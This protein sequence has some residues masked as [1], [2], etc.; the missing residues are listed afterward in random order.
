MS[1]SIRGRHP[2]RKRHFPY[3][4]RQIDEAVM[5]RANDHVR[6][7][8]PGDRYLWALAHHLVYRGGED[9]RKSVRNQAQIKWRHRKMK[10]AQLRQWAYRH[11]RDD[12]SLDEPTNL[13]IVGSTFMES[14]VPEFLVIAVDDD[15]SDGLTYLC[16][17]ENFE[18][19]V[20]LAVTEGGL[21][22]GAFGIQGAY[23]EGPLDITDWMVRACRN[24][25]ADKLD[26]L[27]VSDEDMRS[28]IAGDVELRRCLL[29]SYSK[30]DKGGDHTRGLDTYDREYLLEA[31][32]TFIGSNE[33]WPM[34][35]ADEEEHVFF[36]DL[37][38]EATQS[39][40]LT[41]IEATA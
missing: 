34:A 27:T 38:K 2:N 30:G 14:P 16:E 31:F 19:A 39:G 20:A 25:I 5:R 35:M 33:G 37:V 36:L 10:R 17:A 32:A 12:F 22:T 24:E 21:D 28:I 6:P 15:G 7:A 41:Q 9:S 26:G 23:R 8:D 13:S 1:R 11:S 29:T 3:W 40:K 18:R 4:I